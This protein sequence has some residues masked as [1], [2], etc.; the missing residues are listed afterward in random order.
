M[1]RRVLKSEN[2]QF[3]MIMYPAHDGLTINYGTM[4][5]IQSV[6][7]LSD[8]RSVIETW[9][10]HRFRIINRVETDGY[11]VGQIERY[12]PAIR[13]SDL[14]SLRQPFQHR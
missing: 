5:R 10:T 11:M 7:I 8:G 14:Q 6:K 12:V 4:L 9:G 3:G 13:G 2:K 1:L